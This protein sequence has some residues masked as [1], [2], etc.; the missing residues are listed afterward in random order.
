MMSAFK[1]EVND[2][3]V[4]KLIFD[5]PGEKVNKF[6]KDVMIELGEKI[7]ELKSNTSIK[8]LLVMS[9]KEGIFIAGADVGEIQ[10]M[11]N[12]EGDQSQEARDLITRGVNTFTE[13]ENLP[14]PTVAV[15]NGA[16]MG[17]GLEMS[18][19]CT[20]RVVT[21]HKKTSLGLPEVMLGILPGW[22]GTQRLPKLIGLVNAMPLI[23]TGKKIDAKKAFKLKIADA[24][25]AAEFIDEKIA[26]FVD[27]ILDDKKKKKILSKRNTTKGFM[28]ATQNFL[29]EGNP[30]GKNVVF[31][32]ARE[33]VMKA[34][35]G[36]Y[37]APLAI[38]DLLQDTYGMSLKDGLKRET[39]AFIKLVTTHKSVVKSLVHI[40]FTD[41]AVKKDIGVK[42][43]DDYKVPAVNHSAV[44]GAG[45][46]GGGIAW[47]FSYKDIPVRLKDVNWDG[48]SKGFEAAQD[49]YKVL[50]KKRKLKPT[51]VNMKMHKISGAL[52]YSGFKSSDVVVEAI[53]ENMGIKKTVLQ[54]L[55]GEV[56]NDALICSNTSALSISEMQ[57]V[58]K[59]PERFIG[60]HFFNPVNRMPLVEVIRGE[61]TSDESVAKLVSLVKK[62]G[63]TP[64]VV[65]DCAG[66]LVN[67]ILIPS[68]NE[69]MYLLE[70][71]CDLEEIDKTIYKFGMPMGPFTLAD[72]VGLDVGYKVAKLLEEAYGDRMRVPEFLGKIVEGGLLGKKM[73]KGIYIHKGK[74]RTFNEG[75]QKFL[76]AKKSNSITKEEMVDRFVFTMVNEAARCLEEKVIEKPAYLDLAMIY[77]T[78]FPPFHGGLLKYA[79]SVGV[80]N[81]V[82][83]MN[84]LAQ[85]Y[86]KRFEPCE[87]LKSLAKDNKS[88][89]DL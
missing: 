65:G 71:G 35:K 46:M 56:S 26:E 24:I 6:S 69:G 13:L 72:E 19:A 5:L 33:G 74:S 75:V 17:G 57:S 25:I 1:I 59:H 83:K 63:K 76:P 49:I 10:E 9:A 16:C 11:L 80:T 62:L 36:H 22:G 84:V 18:L 78:G 81:V 38:L 73:G 45:V 21:D 7:A 23:L 48:V 55:E 82:E 85:K 32:K 31:S 4:A 61:K 52:D 29:L 41:D 34:S 54:E 53:V 47:L 30:L 27:T 28:G 37:P 87:L 70:E 14:F 43:P 50:Q 42:M 40:F 86:G 12:K 60:M 2:N 51:Q 64:I 89:Y 58:M 15:I 3:G 79:D 68:M 88:F 39:E 67:R 66:F 20:Y 8:V 44:L 77:G